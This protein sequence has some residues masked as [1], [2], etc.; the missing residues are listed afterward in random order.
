M[1]VKVKKMLGSVSKNNDCGQQVVYDADESYI[2][3]TASGQ[4]GTTPGSSRAR[5]SRKRR[6]PTSTRTASPA[7]S[8]WI[9]MQVS[10]G[11]VEASDDHQYTHKAET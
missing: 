5:W 10:A 9:R 1:R 6:F 11:R 7:R 2:M 8:G 3:D 4:K